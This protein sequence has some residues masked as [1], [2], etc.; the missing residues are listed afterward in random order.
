MEGSTV[1]L[2][3]N[4]DQ[5]VLMTWELNYQQHSNAVVAPRERRGGAGLAAQFYS[6]LPPLLGMATTAGHQR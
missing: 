3:T 6:D 5:G 2:I 4:A 1:A